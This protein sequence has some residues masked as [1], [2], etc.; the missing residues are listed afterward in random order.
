MLAGAPVDI[1]A[2][3]SFLSRAAEET[4]LAVFKELVE[5]GEGR[6]LGRYALQF[7]GPSVLES[8]AIGLVLQSPQPLDSAAFLELEA[9]FCDWYAWTV[10]LPGTYYLEVVERLFKENQ[11]A[12]GRFVALGERVDLADVRTPLFL[13][14]AR[15]DELVAP[16]QIFATEHL[17]STPAH[18]IRKVIAPCGHLGLF[19]GR[20]ALVEIWPRIARW[21]ALPRDQRRHAF[22]HSASAHAEFIARRQA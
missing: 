11:L 15:D 3:Q 19:M 12:T 18:H 8:E 20:P 22:D 2:G 17:V 6:M 4:P 13:L 7:W 10:D 16:T 1:A 5:L 14:A 9:R 21:L